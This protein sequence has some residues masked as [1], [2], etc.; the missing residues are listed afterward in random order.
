MAVRDRR[1]HEQSGRFDVRHDRHE[2]DGLMIR[3]LVD[4]QRIHETA[5][6]VAGI[7]NASN[8]SN[9]NT[10]NANAAVDA[11]NGTNETGCVA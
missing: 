9:D 10:L 4:L 7:R 11:V 3:R 8:N 2:I 6:V 1:V 5:M